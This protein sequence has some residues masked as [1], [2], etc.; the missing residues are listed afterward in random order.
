MHLDPHFCA[1]LK[2][3]LDFGG[4]LGLDLN[5]NSRFNPKQQ[6]IEKIGN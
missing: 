2:G 4:S 1:Q 3:L 5:V 6:P